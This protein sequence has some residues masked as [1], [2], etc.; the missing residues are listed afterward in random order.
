MKIY[1]LIFFF[2]KTLFYMF[3]KTTVDFCLRLSMFYMNNQQYNIRNKI[4][5]INNCL[6]E[7]AFS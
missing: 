5:K 6:N 7:I 2:I 3:Y 1:L 4:P